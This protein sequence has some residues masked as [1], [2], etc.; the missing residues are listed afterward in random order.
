M[1]GGSNIESIAASLQEAR[2]RVLALGGA[3][4]GR[5]LCE[6]EERA[7][8][9]VADILR[10]AAELPSHEERGMAVDQAKKV[11]CMVVDRWG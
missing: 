5:E 4:I 2:E 1:T 10:H 8:R 6:T 11:L 3:R 7:I 9:G